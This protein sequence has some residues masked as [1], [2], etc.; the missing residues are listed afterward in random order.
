MLVAFATGAGSVSTGGVVSTT[1]TT[2]AAVV[3]ALP[4]ASRAVHETVVLPSGNVEPDAG[5]H[6]TASTPSTR[7]VAV[8]FAKVTIAPAGPEASAVTSACAPIV[9]AV[10]SFTTTANVDVAPL[11]DLSEA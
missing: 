10:V 6:V 3:V 8:G 7:S 5:A 9:G 11:P 4:C 2:K 1:C